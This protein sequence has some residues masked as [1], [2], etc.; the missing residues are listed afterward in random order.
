M[1]VNKGFVHDTQN[2]LIFSQSCADLPRNSR[3]DTI[4]III[5]RISQNSEAFFESKAP[6]EYL[7]KYF[8]YFKFGFEIQWFSH[9]D[10]MNG[11]SALGMAASLGI[12]PIIE[13]IVNLV[14]TKLLNV[15]N[16]Q[17]LTPL[18]LAAGVEN[19]IAS[20]NTAAYLLKLGA[21]VNTNSPPMLAI[22]SKLGGTC[23]EKVN[24]KSPLTEAA[25]HGNI[26]TAALLLRHGARTDWF[27]DAANQNSV[28]Y[29]NIQKAKKYIITDTEKL[30]LLGSRCRDSLL[31][32]LVP[33][34]ISTILNMKYRLGSPLLGEY[35]VSNW[36][37][38]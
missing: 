8:P 19:H 33:D 2:S 23:K 35:S 38:C 37:K 24:I 14:G 4:N 26:L 3:V 7:S 20:Y 25:T 32:L 17:G 36:N 21:E 29:K 31:F 28:A 13:M 5:K 6:D 34:V 10:E 1:F 22:I 12:L 18:H 27:E 15:G 16:R 11:D 9:V 30:F